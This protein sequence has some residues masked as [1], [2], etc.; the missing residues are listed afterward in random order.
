MVVINSAL[1]YIRDWLNTAITYGQ[2]GTDTTLPTQSDSGLFS[3]ESSTLNATSNNTSDNPATL[4][5]THVITTPQ[6][7]G[8]D[9]SEW[10]VRINSNTEAFNRTVTAPLPKTGTQEVTRIVTIEITQD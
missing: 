10:E 9:L 3:P 1:I 5:V 8:E 7:V 2:A 4:H 6:A